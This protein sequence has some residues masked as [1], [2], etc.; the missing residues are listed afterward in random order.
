MKKTI[1][2]IF[3]LGNFQISH[4][5][6]NRSAQIFLDEMA[7][8]FKGEICLIPQLLLED[9]IGNKLL[10]YNNR[11]DQI[12]LPSIKFDSISTIQSLLF[13]QFDGKIVNFSETVN[14]YSINAVK[15]YEDGFEFIYRSKYSFNENYPD[16]D[17]VVLFLPHNEIRKSKS[18]QAKVL[19]KFLFEELWRKGIFEFDIQIAS[20]LIAEFQ[21][22]VFLE[23]NR[24]LLLTKNNGFYEK[25]DSMN[26]LIH[27][28]HTISSEDLEKLNRIDFSFIYSSPIIIDYFLD[29]KNGKLLINAIGFG[30]VPKNGSYQGVGFPYDFYYLQ[31]KD[32]KK[33]LSGRSYSLLF[34]LV[35]TY[36]CR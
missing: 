16:T 14:L 31:P 19:S 28:S 36:F 4:A 22:D 25:N 32:L 30:I 12:E 2:I 18:K 1:I 8:M 15:I 20:K 21:V 35:D 11:K 34:H 9:T 33:V 27:E 13:K 24:K 26:K 17:I 3:L 29:S 5:Q 7:E 10:F 23:S 6:Q